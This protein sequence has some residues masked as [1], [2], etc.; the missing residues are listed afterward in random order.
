M[1]I[2]SRARE[3]NL[4]LAE[5]EI[6]C[7]KCNLKLNYGRCTYIAMNGKGYIY[8]KNGGKLKEMEEITYLG[9]ILT[10]DAGRMRELSHRFG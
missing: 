6:E 9:G 7:A 4:L 5:I 3:L 10:K 1:L 2:G 8:F